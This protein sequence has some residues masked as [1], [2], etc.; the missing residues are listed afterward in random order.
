MITAS[1]LRRAGSLFSSFI[2]TALAVK[3]LEKIDPRFGKF[4]TNAAAAGFGT[5]QALSYLRNKFL[6]GTHGD[7]KRM[8]ESRVS[9]GIARP[10]EMASLSQIRS[11]DRPVDMAQK[12]ISVGVGLGAGF[13]SDERPEEQPKEAPSPQRAGQGPLQGMDEATKAANERTDFYRKYGTYPE[14]LAQPQ[15]QPQVQPKAQPQAQPK[16][17]PQ[18][19]T[20]SSGAANFIAQ[21]P[22]LGAFL[23]Q[24]MEKGMSVIQAA[25]EA[26]KVRKLLPMIQDIEQNIGQP[27]EDILTQL[28]L[29]SQQGGQQA[30]QGTS[31]QQN[32]QLAQLADLIKQYMGST[33][34]APPNG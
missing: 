21:H 14:N 32:P 26:R 29:G 20:P 5:D 33:G 9:E 27:L 16:V 19:S 13:M 28:F 6:S 23:D 2:P 30:Q 11:Q 15:V 22:E 17:S 12:A 25:T 4:F 18:V 8:L 31:Q 10:D 24:K 3:G 7:D 34:R 1:I